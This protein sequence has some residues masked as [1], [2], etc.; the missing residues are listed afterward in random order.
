PQPA[1]DHE[2]L[3]L[4]LA[5]P[6]RNLRKRR[7]L[8]LE[9]VV[10]DLAGPGESRQV[11]RT[12]QLAIGIVGLQLAAEVGADAGDRA[13]VATVVDEHRVDRARGNGHRVPGRQLR[14]RRDPPPR[15]VVRHEDGGRA[16][17]GAALRL[18]RRH[19]VQRYADDHR[20]RRRAEAYQPGAA[21]GA[22]AEARPLG[23]GYAEFR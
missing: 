15:A 22:A 11:A 18:M 16:A 3:Y 21:A 20:G 14:H 13:D 17:A 6:D 5:H 23:T 1:A 19:L 7:R 12:V 2:Q 10:E 8:A 4:T 9:L